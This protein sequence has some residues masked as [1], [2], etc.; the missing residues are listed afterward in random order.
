MYTIYSIL[1]FLLCAISITTLVYIGVLLIKRCLLCVNYEDE[2]DI[3]APRKHSEHT[4]FT[5][6]NSNEKVINYN[7]LM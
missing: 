4:N 1:L 6:W 3:E 2:Y 7:A 5:R